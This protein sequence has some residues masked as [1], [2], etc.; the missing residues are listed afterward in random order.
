MTK[1][2]FFY[3]VCNCFL[4]CPFLFCS[5]LRQKR[6]FMK[7]IESLST[8]TRKKEIYMDEKEIRKRLRMQKQWQCEDELSEEITGTSYDANHDHFR[9]CNFINTFIF[10]KL[11]TTVTLQPIIKINKNTMY[12]NF[13]I[14]TILT[15]FIIHKQ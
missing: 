3:K 7:Y 14:Q 8:P 5:Y 2:T 11:L 10:L 9:G 1:S 6:C 15:F 12:A 13:P 4:L